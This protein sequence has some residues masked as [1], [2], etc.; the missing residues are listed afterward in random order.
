MGFVEGLARPLV[1]WSA[2]PL[3]PGP[4]V[5][6]SAGPLV[7]GSLVLVPLAR[8]FSGPPVPWSFGPVVLWS[9]GPRVLR[10]LGSC[11]PCSLVFLGSLVDSL[12]LSDSL[13]RWVL[14]PL[15][16]C[17][18]ACS[19]LWSLGPVVSSARFSTCFVVFGS[20]VLWFSRDAVKSSPVTVVSSTIP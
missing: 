12:W 6:W 18:S 3:V 19:V 2:G 10:S 4:L 14:N 13:V 5:L 15:I 17:L 16:P 1:R 8:L 7:F 9:A 11:G 20:L